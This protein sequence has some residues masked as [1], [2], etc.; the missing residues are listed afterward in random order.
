MSVR[1]TAVEGHIVSTRF[2]VAHVDILDPFADTM[3]LHAL[4]EYDVNGV[5]VEHVT[6]TIPTLIEEAQRLRF[7]SLN[8]AGKIWPSNRARPK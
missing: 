5:L 1:R 6:I 8:D 7:A 2:E 3:S 4:T